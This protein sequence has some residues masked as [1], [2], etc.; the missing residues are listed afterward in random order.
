MMTIVNCFGVAD[1]ISHKKYFCRWFSYSGND[2]YNNSRHEDET[3]EISDEL[4]L[5]YTLVGPYLGV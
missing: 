2:M 4:V 1:N 5:Y 3:N